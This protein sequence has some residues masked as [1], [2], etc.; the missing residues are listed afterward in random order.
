M[1]GDAIGV[2]PVSCVRVLVQ[3]DKASLGRK[4]TGKVASM[5]VLT[6]T[7]QGTSAYDKAKEDLSALRRQLAGEQKQRAMVV[8]VLAEMR[9]F[10]ASLA[11]E[12]AFLRE[13]HDLGTAGGTVGGTLPAAVE[14]ELAQLR[15]DNARLRSRVKALESNRPTAGHEPIVVAPSTSESS[16][17]ATGS[18]A[19][20]IAEA[21]V[22][23]A[24]LR[25]EAHDFGGSGRSTGSIAGVGDD[26]NGSGAN[27]TA[28]GSSE[29]DYDRVLSS[30]KDFSGAL[31]GLVEQTP[32]APLDLKNQLAT[33]VGICKTICGIVPDADG[34]IEDDVV[35]LLRAGLELLGDMDSEALRSEMN[36]CGRTLA[37][38]IQQQVKGW[39]ANRPRS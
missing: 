27:T 8:G 16:P 4:S 13:R 9:S 17:I 10:A 38:T 24:S 14:E 29:D 2:F 3:F 34:R 11:S 32:A 22:S 20:Q 12:L 6:L 30:V 39:V 19:E 7:G 33:V 35:S 18:L 26:R 37:G 31:F 23:I 15:R 25:D 28:A 5:R 36:A 1:I 21:R